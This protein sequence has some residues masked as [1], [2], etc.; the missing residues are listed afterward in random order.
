[1]SSGDGDD[2]EFFRLYIG[3]ALNLRTRLEQH[4]DPD[5]RKRYSTLQYDIMDACNRPLRTIFYGH[6]STTLLEADP[7][8][9]Y[10][11]ISLR[12]LAS[13]SFRPY[14]Q[15]RWSD[16]CQMIL[17]LFIRTRISMLYRHCFRT[18]A[19]SL[20]EDISRKT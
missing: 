14:L 4:G 16:T 5:H 19:V 18:E 7:D 6:F 13:L 9:L 3:Q 12:N 2:P 8:M 10:I 1:M 15:R 20:L 17:K 11:L